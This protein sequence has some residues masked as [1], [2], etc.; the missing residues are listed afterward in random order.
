VLVEEGQRLAHLPFQESYS[1]E[2]AELF[3]GARDQQE[4]LAKYRHC[5]KLLPFDL[6]PAIHQAA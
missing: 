1:F 2:L 3:L 4:L 5:L 6:E